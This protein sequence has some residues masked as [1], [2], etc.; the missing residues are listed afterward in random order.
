MKATL[1]FDLDDLDDRMAHLRC[2]KSTDMASVLWQ[3]V[4]N[5]E[6]SVQYE[7][8]GFEADSDPSDGVYAAFRRIRELMD[9]H[10]IVIDD[11]IN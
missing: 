4:T 3:I 1:E 10:G 7:V 2:V 5:L 6:K 8:E 9:D 11:L